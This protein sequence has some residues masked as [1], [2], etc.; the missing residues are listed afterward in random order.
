[1][2][3][4]LLRNFT[5]AACEKSAFGLTLPNIECFS[6][7]LGFPLVVTLDLLRIDFTGN[8]CGIYIYYLL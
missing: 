2:E 1:M 5:L 6:R 4:L 7:L 3:G 8:L